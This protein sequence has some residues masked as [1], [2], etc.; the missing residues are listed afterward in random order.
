MLAVLA[1]EFSDPDSHVR[2]AALDSFTKL[3]VTLFDTAGMASRLSYE[4]V[5]LGH[6]SLSLYIYFVFFVFV[7]ITCPLQL[8]SPPSLNTSL[9]LDQ[10][11]EIIR[12][13]LRVSPPPVDAL[14]RPDSTL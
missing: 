12:F 5:L 6:I 1:Q 2:R 14:R 9:S 8:Y 11:S 7:Y 4:P 3:A 10:N 13:T